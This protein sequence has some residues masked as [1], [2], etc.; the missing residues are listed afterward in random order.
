[1]K[2]KLILTGIV[3]TV[4]ASA[5]LGGMKVIKSKKDDKK[6]QDRIEVVSYGKFVVKNTEIGNLEPLISVEV[7]S[8][9]EG[10]IERLFVEEGDFVNKDDVLLQIDDKQIRE[11]SNQAKANLDAAQAQYDQAV[12]NTRL[13]EKQRDSAIELAKDSL[14]SAQANLEAIQATNVQRIAQEETSISTTQTALEQDRIALQQAEIAFQQAQLSLEQFQSAEK[15]AQVT[16]QTAESELNRTRELY[17]KK[18]VARK[19][20]EDAEARYATALSQDESAKKTVESQRKSLDSLEQSVETRKKA[21]ESRQTTLDFQRRNLSAIKD[22]HAATE[23]QAVSQLRSANITLKQLQETIDREKRISEL[24]ATSANA[25]LV[26]AKSNLKNQ[27]ERLEWTTVKA[28]MSGTITQLIVE[29]GEIITSGRSAFTQGPPIMTIADLSKMLVKTQLNEVDM[30]KIKL[31][32][33]AEIRAS[34]YPDKKFEGKVSKIA[35]AGQRRPEQNIITFE[36][37]IEVVGSP[38]EL[39]P[40]MSVDVDIIVDDRERVLQ[41]PIE[42]VLE[43]S[44]IIVK[45]TLSGARLRNLSPNQAVKLENRAGKKFEGKIA[46][47]LTDKNEENVEIVMEGTPRELRLGNSEMTL[48]LSEQEKLQ[49]IP[50]NISSE[51]QFYVMLDKP[52]PESKGRKMDK[53]EKE[54]AEK[55]KKLNIKGVKTP[56][57]VGERN[58]RAIE[59]TGGLKEGT[60]VFVPS[61]EAIAQWQAEKK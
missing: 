8:N 12:E 21:I 35:P 36:I 6:E 13:T 41:L 43:E 57:Q 5:I 3:I 27:D 45:A 58:D 9:V 52:E 29:E 26:R 50:V 48:I 19:S 16:L 54:A 23:K 24:S 51:K 34:A 28:P 11:E 4:L 14:D 33:R 15:S 46:Q 55:K 39:H 56:I 40:G 17:D 25:N 42:A 53:E 7:K 32:Q 31:N 20:L 18:L 37:E 2:K 44:A 47:L 49:R 22:A 38:K 61:L 10:E 60:R 1:V 30:A 59:I